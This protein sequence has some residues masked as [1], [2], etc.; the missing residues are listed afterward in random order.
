[1]IT[2]HYEAFNKDNPADKVPL[3]IRVESPLGELVFEKK[4]S[5]TSDFTIQEPM[6]GEYRLCFTSKSKF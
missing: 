4:D 1:M 5:A 3:N 2:A 6:E